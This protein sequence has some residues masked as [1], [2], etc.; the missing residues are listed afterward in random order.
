MS[1]ASSGDA[2]LP[3]ADPSRSSRESQLSTRAPGHRPATAA[4]LRSA[5]TTTARAVPT[6]PMR[7]LTPLTTTSGSNPAS[8]R[9]RRRAGDAEA[10]I[11]RG[12]MGKTVLQRPQLRNGARASVS[13]PGSPRP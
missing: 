12:A 1:V 13:A 2:G 11:N 6:F 7:S 3:S 8:R 4:P 10:R 5:R 9:T